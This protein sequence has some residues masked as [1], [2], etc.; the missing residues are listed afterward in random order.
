MLPYGVAL[1]VVALV[2]PALPEPDRLGLTAVA[3]APALLT[4]PALATA[5]GGRM[6]RAGA[7]VVGSIGMWLVLTLTRGPAAAAAAQGAM[8]PFVL[9]AGV[10]S[11]VPMLPQLVRTVAQRVGDLAFL[12]LIAIAL[13]GAGELNAANG[14][15][16]LALSVAIAATTGVVARI[17]GVDLRSALAGAGSRDPA[18]ATGLA[19]AVGGSV[20]IPLYSGLLLL[21]GSA[22]LTLWNRRKAR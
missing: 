13:S 21:A 2:G 1:A 22:V 4:A 10:T 8:L 19:I 16:A 9:G 6:D 18:V 5:I 14:L 15:A 12:V 11:I 3:V 20:A 17:G 7:L